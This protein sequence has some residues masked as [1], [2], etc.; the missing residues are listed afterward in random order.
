M[1]GFTNSNRKL[2]AELS[3]KY[4]L[5][6]IFGFREYPEA[7]GMLS[8]GANLSD[9]Y[10]RAAYF[11]DRIFKGASPSNLP[12]EE[13]TRFELVVNLRTVEVLGFRIPSELLIAADEIIR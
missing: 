7:G 3:L 12:P 6:S 13:P 9:G 1:S 10:R 4:R 2:I 11:V 8:Y 5:A